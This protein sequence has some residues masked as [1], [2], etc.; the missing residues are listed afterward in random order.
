[1]LWIRSLALT[2]AIYFVLESFWRN[3][4]P[5]W[6]LGADCAPGAVGYISSPTAPAA[7]GPDWK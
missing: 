7:D 3:I 5:N 2:Y 6:A 1:M 4:F